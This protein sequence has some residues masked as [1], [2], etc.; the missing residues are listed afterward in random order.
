MKKKNGVA[1]AT[2]FFF[3]A[4]G[5]R[6]VRALPERLVVVMKNPAG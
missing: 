4:A 1:E 5:R 3:C 2:P 6:F